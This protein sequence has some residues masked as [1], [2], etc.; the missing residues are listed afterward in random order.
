MAGNL[1]GRRSILGETGRARPRCSCQNRPVRRRDVLLAASLAAF[2]RVAWSDPEVSHDDT[3][4]R[5]LAGMSQ[6]GGA[7]NA[8]QWGAFAAAE[9]ERWAR[10]LPRIQSMRAWAAREVAPVVTS[11]MPLLYP[12]GGPD[13]LHAVTLFAN[14]DHVVLVGLEPVRSLPSDATVADGGYLRDLATATSDLHRLTFFR[15]HELQTDMS[16]VGVL[17]PLLGSLVR[18]GGWIRR[19]VV[20]GDSGAS[21]EWES[22]RGHPRR[23]EYM[24]VDL[25]NGSLSRRGDVVATLRSLAPHATLLKAASYLLGEPRFSHL[26]ELLLR[27]SATI[28]QDD[29]GLP[30]REIGGRWSVRLFGRYVPPGSP[31]QDRVQDDLEAAFVRGPVRPLPFGV[32]YHV[33]AH[34]SNLLLASRIAE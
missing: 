30:Y 28:L 3:V 19:V 14:V 10:S 26:R 15:T 29:T 11:S 2:P 6:Q 1:T 7:P 33:T 25:A 4:A 31:F 16:E 34:D 32:G 17:P 20:M 5:W 9:D 22:P 8:P 23:L 27:G 12:F 21:I 24:S 18:L 13:A